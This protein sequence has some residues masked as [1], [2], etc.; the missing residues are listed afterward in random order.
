MSIIDILHSQLVRDTVLVPLA[1]IVLDLITGVVAALR[2][3]IFSGKEVMDFAHAEVLPYIA[4][5]AAIVGM[6]LVGTPVEVAAAAYSLTIAGFVSREVSSIVENVGEIAYIPGLSVVSLLTPMIQHLLPGAKLNA[7]NFPT[8]TV[9]TGNIINIASA[10]D[11]PGQPANP[12][13][14]DYPQ[15]GPHASA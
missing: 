2:L 7:T 5:L 9:T 11:A 8:A 10:P 15:D 12:T 1:L 4:I 6:I 3:G 13:S 14:F